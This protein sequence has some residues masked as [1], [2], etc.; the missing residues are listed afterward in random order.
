MTVA[1]AVLL[2]AVTMPEK[3][4]I[5]APSEKKAK[6][7]MGYIIEHTFDSPLFYKQLEIDTSLERVKRERSKNRLTFKGGGEVMTLTLDARNSRR[8]LEAAMGFGAPNVIL[9]ESS[10]VDDP[11]YASVK[12]MLGGYK[13]N[14]LFEIGNPF[15]RNHFHRTT[16]DTRYLHL[17]ADYRTAIEEGRFTEDFI[18][19]MRGEAFFDVYYECK[20][21]DEDIIDDKGYRQLFT[22]KDLRMADPDPVGRPRLGCDIGGGGDY[23]VYVVRWD[24]KAMLA[25]KNQS[26]DTM[27]NVI[28]IERMVEKYGVKWEDVHID[29]IGIGRGVTDRLREKGYS[30]NGVSVGGK[31]SNKKFLN[32]KAQIYWK[33]REWAKNGHFVPCEVSYK[34]IWDQL[35][36]IKYKVNTEKQIK[37]EPKEDL[38]KRTGKSPDYAD[39]FSLTFNEPKHIGVITL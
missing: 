16:K 30:V 3:W 23:N 9:D 6:I 11:L 4:L 25:G 37:L 17:F 21:P 26:K 28:E 34:S 5:V 22:S 15:Y 7:I 39:A 35:L 19:E 32:K 36:W 31:A 14:F 10:L 20:F 1:L 38:K 27:T 18:E 24:N 33:A 13:D 12:R 2:R 8:S 29:D